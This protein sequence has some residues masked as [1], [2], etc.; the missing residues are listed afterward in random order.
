M[1]SVASDYGQG[2]PFA[3]SDAQRRNRQ[4]PTITPNPITGFLVGADVVLQRGPDPAEARPRILAA[5]R[6]KLAGYQV[7]RIFKIVE[8]IEVGPSGK[9]G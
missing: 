1:A 4:N 5:C 2:S 6:E 7:P 9:K 8:S 3:A